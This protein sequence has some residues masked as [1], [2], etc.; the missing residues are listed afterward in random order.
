[1]CACGARE[2]RGDVAPSNRMGACD[3]RQAAVFAARS[4]PR[5]VGWLCRAWEAFITGPE[6]NIMRL[7]GVAGLGR[8]LMEAWGG[9]WS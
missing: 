3:Q 8:A 2:A 1:M 5:S 6:W 7:T 4:V 9:A